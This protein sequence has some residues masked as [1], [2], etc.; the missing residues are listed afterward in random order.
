VFRLLLL[1]IIAGCGL[2]TPEEQAMKAKCDPMVK[3][4]GTTAR[5]GVHPESFDV[6]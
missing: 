2:L 3:Q 1:L 5:I 4:H 6:L